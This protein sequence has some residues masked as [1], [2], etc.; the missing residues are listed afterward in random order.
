MISDVAYSCEMCL[1]WTLVA[2][3]VCV[4]LTLSSTNAQESE[5]L[6]IRPIEDVVV[7]EMPRIA[8]ARRM[9]PS[10]NHDRDFE[11]PAPAVHLREAGE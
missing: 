9:V 4:F 2:G 6:T 10:L 3:F 7:S 5:N 8:E 1:K 11:A